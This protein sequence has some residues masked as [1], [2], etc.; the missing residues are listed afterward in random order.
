MEGGVS[1]CKEYR[2][3]AC[4]LRGYIAMARVPECSA[5]TRPPPWLRGPPWVRGRRN[6]TKP[7]G[8]AAP[9]HLMV[10]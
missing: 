10:E 2:R 5:I 1:T 3:G 7:R 4:G 8:V 6:V 9:V